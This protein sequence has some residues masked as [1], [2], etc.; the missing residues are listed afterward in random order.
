MGT[1][2]GDNLFLTWFAVIGVCLTLLAS[3]TWLTLALVATHSV[4]AY[5]TVTA[6]ALHTF[7]DI[8]LTSL[9][10]RGRE[11]YLKKS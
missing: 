1:S 8:N 7:V 5:S 9:T 10:L 4:L 3:V 2:N 6:W 11:R